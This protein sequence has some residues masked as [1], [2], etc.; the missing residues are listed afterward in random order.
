MRRT[1]AVILLASTV[2]LGA[3]L[4]K[5]HLAEPD[6]LPKLA[7]KLLRERMM[8][9]GDQMSQLVIAVT[10]LQ[11]ERV[12]AIAGDI[13]SEPRL[14][15]PMPGDEDALNA[16][17]PNQLFVYQDELRLRTKALAAAADRPNDPGL[18]Q[19]FGKVTETCVSC[20]SA[21]LHPPEQPPEN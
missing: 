21:F 19:A 14:V 2:T 12:R 4:P 7:R 3:D 16:A 5:G 17:L 1:L 10:L 15:R 6:Y 20:H 8:R 13:A 11:R 18:A 9:H